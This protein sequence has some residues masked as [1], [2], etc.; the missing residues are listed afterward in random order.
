MIKATYVDYL[1]QTGCIVKQFQSTFSKLSKA[2]LI[3]QINIIQ[4]KKRF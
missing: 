1:L 3:R 4:Q 2:K